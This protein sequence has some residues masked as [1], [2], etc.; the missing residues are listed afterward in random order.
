MHKSLTPLLLAAALVAAIAA[1]ANAA[2]IAASPGGNIQATINGLGFSGPFLGLFSCNV[3]LNGNVS[4]G[5][6]S[7]PGQGGSISGATINSCSGGHSVVPTSL[8]WRLTAQT[9]LRCPSSSTGILGVVAAAFRV[10][11]I[12]STSGNIGTLVSSGT[13]KI[14][15]LSSSLSSGGQVLSKGGT[16]SPVNTITCS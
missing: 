14:S 6:I 12:F 9:A 7:L 8:P 13:G 4:A 2:T 15:I 11:G 3:T 10:D 1:N 16:Y 5:P